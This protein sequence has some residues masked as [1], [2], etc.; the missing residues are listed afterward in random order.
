MKRYRLKL[1]RPIYKTVIYIELSANSMN[2]A[3]L[4]SR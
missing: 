2:E 4:K 1:T 3:M